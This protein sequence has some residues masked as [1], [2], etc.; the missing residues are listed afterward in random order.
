MNL[1]Q[2]CDPEYLTKVR[3]RVY[4][5]ERSPFGVH[6]ITPEAGVLYISIV[7]ISKR[8]NP[9]DLN[10]LME[11]VLT[12]PESWSLQTS[13][14]GCHGKGTLPDDGVLVQ[15]A[16]VSWSHGL[17][18]CIDRIITDHVVVDQGL[19]ETCAISS[20]P[21]SVPKDVVSPRQPGECLRGI[22]F[23]GYS[24]QGT[25]AVLS[26]VY[27][28][29]RYGMV[30]HATRPGGI[31]VNL[32]TF[33]A[34]AAGNSI[35]WKRVLE[36]IPTTCITMYCTLEDPIPWITYGSTCTRTIRQVHPLIPY[37][38]GIRLLGT[39]EWNRVA[40]TT[41]NN[42]QLYQKFN[43][44]RWVSF[45]R[46][47][48]HIIFNQHL[49]SAYL[50]ACD[51]TISLRD[52][53]TR[54][55]GQTLE[56][57]DIDP[58]R[59]IQHCRRDSPPTPIMYTYSFLGQLSTGPPH[60]IPSSSNPTNPQTDS[61]LTQLVQL[62]NLI[63]RDYIIGVANERTITTMS[64]SGATN[65]NGVIGRGTHVP[66]LDGLLHK[67]KS[68]GRVLQ[69]VRATIQRRMTI[70]VRVI[71]NVEAWVRQQV[72]CIT[73]P[74]VGD[75]Q[76]KIK[77]RLRILGGVVDNIKHESVVT[78]LILSPGTTQR[79]KH[80]HWL[81]QRRLFERTVIV[82]CKTVNA[83][84]VLVE[85]STKWTRVDETIGTSVVHVDTESLSSGLRT[86]LMTLALLAVYMLFEGGLWY[87]YNTASVLTPLPAGKEPPGAHYDVG[88]LDCVVLMLRNLI[89][90]VHTC[91][92]QRCIYIP[93]DVSTAFTLSKSGNT[94]LLSR[95]FHDLVPRQSIDGGRVTG[96]GHQNL[97]VSR[98]FFCCYRPFFHRLDDC[99]VDNILYIACLLYGYATSQGGP[100]T[101]APWFQ[102]S[103][104][105]HSDPI[106]CDSRST[107]T[108]EKVNLSL[109]M[110]RSIRYTIREFGLQLGYDLL[111]LHL[112]REWVIHHVG[113]HHGLHERG[114]PGVETTIGATVSPNTTHATTVIPVT[115]AAST[116][117]VSVAM[118]P[119]SI[120]ARSATPL[121]RWWKRNI[122]IKSKRWSMGGS[123]IWPRGG[124]KVHVPVTASTST[125]HSTRTSLGPGM[126]TVPGS[127]TEHQPRLE[128]TGAYSQTN[129]L[130]ILYMLEDLLG[131]HHILS[132]GSG[133]GGN[134]VTGLCYSRSY[135]HIHSSSHSSHS[136]KWYFK[137]TCCT[138]TLLSRRVICLLSVVL[139][140]T[141]GKLQYRCMSLLGHIL[142]YYPSATI[143][144]LTQ[145]GTI[146][147][148][149]LLPLL[150]HPDVDFRRVVLYC[151][152]MLCK[153]LTVSRGGVTR[154]VSSP[155]KGSVLDPNR[156]MDALSCLLSETVRDNM[157]GTRIRTTVSK[158][159][160][161]SGLTGMMVVSEAVVSVTRLCA[162]IIRYIIRVPGYKLVVSARLGGNDIMVD[163]LIA[164]LRKGCEV[165]G[166]SMGGRTNDSQSEYPLFESNTRSQPCG[167]Q[168]WCE[169]VLEICHLFR[170][171]VK[172]FT[173][174]N[175]PV[176]H[177]TID[178][179]QLLLF[180]TVLYCITT[181]P[182][183]GGSSDSW[184]YATCV[185][186]DILV[187]IVN[188]YRGHKEVYSNLLYRIWLHPTCIM[189][190][191]QF[192]VVV[193]KHINSKAPSTNTTGVQAT[194]VYGTP[195]LSVHALLLNL[196]WCNRPTRDKNELVTNLSTTTGHLERFWMANCNIIRYSGT[197][198][199][200][201]M[202]Y[203]HSISVEKSCGY[204]VGGTNRILMY[205]TCLLDRICTITKA[206]ESEPPSTTQG[207]DDTVKS[208][209]QVDCLDLLN[210]EQLLSCLAKHFHSSIRLGTSRYPG[211][212]DSSNYECDMVE[213]G[214]V[215]FQMATINIISHVVHRQ[216]ATLVSVIRGECIQGCILLISS[217]STNP[218]LLKAAHHLLLSIS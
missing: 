187:Y 51:T 153:E 22:H 196:P 182:W 181:E 89:S 73:H 129:L 200:E 132:G 214:L 162:T 123:R 177:V 206:Q 204:Q 94:F 133:E 107:T 180:N 25:M 116:V 5:L 105:C 171:T 97:M 102:A 36:Y 209:A 172:N 136:S 78:S 6:V 195:I 199:S 139:R 210:H 150:C 146:F 190:L 11:Y 142:T 121:K 55:R 202:L 184:V 115:V 8:K 28:A 179:H 125:C 71:H 70:L 170:V 57:V 141:T 137:G 201:S 39:V 77:H 183:G 169:C 189:R 54:R 151:M 96:V 62:P 44:K 46:E 104:G 164:L 152:T 60:I 45:V 185:M 81:R 188:S 47:K 157:G 113:L 128:M 21:L 13:V 159:E 26:A 138:R 124:F 147:H 126:D 1:L 158:S 2:Y 114:G 109:F 155:V 32:T 50:E 23:I 90:S 49:L 30:A 20:S 156:L 197:L 101:M 168:E 134:S 29:S 88:Q 56:A 38:G 7:P 148:G 165:H 80:A 118:T 53:P 176:T 31:N 207:Y 66:F 208:I 167:D 93:T 84:G 193:V 15:G 40:A 41:V 59:E 99:K 130:Q 122:P 58:T 112:I 131:V 135:R 174:P 205:A 106:N 64:G 127:T 17:F 98:Y 3:S 24:I 87:Q 160:P 75:L 68:H 194:G 216:S 35:F 140:L 9:N 212:V 14:T 85:Q 10:I 52:P 74:D 161:T 43:A 175:D 178:Q 120:G 72:E 65:R 42:L 100:F 111:A 218:L 67:V 83:I 82:L 63:I 154:G 27:V 149:L 143:T 108:E 48:V 173:Y 79:P 215:E 16:C 211:G 191:C 145:N 192:V 163:T 117:D 203:Y 33:G 37:P 198:T 76:I 61:Q 186:V 34:P 217:E 69:D 19:E 119:N 95:L 86:N 4:N 12:A 166:V 213:G 18:E 103:K 110:R 92:Q 144:L 91:I